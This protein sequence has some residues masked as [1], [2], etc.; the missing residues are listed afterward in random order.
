MAS[1]NRDAPAYQ[2]Y[3]AAMLAKVDFRTMTLAERGLLYTMR[4]ECWVNSSLPSD[5][6]KLAKIIGFDRDDVIAALPSVIAFFSDDG[7]VITCPELENYRSYLASIRAAQSEGGKRTQA[8]KKGSGKKPATSANYGDS[9]CLAS[10]LAGDLKLLSTVQS[11]P[12]QLNKTQLSGI[13]EINDEFV[14][15]YNKASNGE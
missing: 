2:E 11:S 4:L 3:A 6:A 1:Q 10:N 12:A 8:Q 7:G 5:S 9:G 15:A 13:G 14:D